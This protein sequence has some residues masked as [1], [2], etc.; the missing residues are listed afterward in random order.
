MQMSII[1]TFFIAVCW[2]FFLAISKCWMSN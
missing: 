2:L 1:L